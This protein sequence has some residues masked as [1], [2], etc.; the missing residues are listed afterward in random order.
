MGSTYATG[1]LT[2]LKTDDLGE[3][4]HEVIAR[5]G[6]VIDTVGK[7]GWSNGVGWFDLADYLAAQS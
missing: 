1:P 4:Q 2:F 7:R 5:G 3:A 6:E